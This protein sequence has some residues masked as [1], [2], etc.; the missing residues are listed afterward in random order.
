M[1]ISESATPRRD[2]RPTPASPPLVPTRVDRLIRADDQLRLTIEYLNLDA[3]PGG[4]TL[5]VVDPRQPFTGVR[6][7]F[8]S[9]HTVEDPIATGD[10]VPDRGVDHRTARDSRLV[11]ALPAGTPYALKATLDLAARS[12]ELDDRSVPGRKPSPSGEPGADVTALE[13]VDSLIFSP[14]PE[15]RFRAGI[16]PITRDDVTELWRARLESDPATP[17]LR[18]R[19]RAVWSRPDDPPFDRP[20]DADDRERIVTATTVDPAESGVRW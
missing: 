7:I 4:D 17:E 1:A 14:E 18:P 11:F 5:V 10:P 13:V 19:L 15:G 12:L 8:G 3:D 20:L 16:A 6:L 9:Q 2:T